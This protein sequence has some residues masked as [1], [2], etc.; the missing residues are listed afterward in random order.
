MKKILFILLGLFFYTGVFSQNYSTAARTATDKLV[1]LYH[2]NKEQKVQM[3]KIQE[4]KV[5]NLKDIQPLEAKDSE[6]YYKKKK[7]VSYQE[8]SAIKRLLHPDQK[9]IFMAE[10]KKKRNKQAALMKQLKSQGASMKEI[11]KALSKLD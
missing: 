8:S 6:L 10:A 11:H 7:V 4:R 9:R 3:L 1:K 2:L 5:K